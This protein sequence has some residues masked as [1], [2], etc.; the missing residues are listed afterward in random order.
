MSQ[1]RK[2]VLPSLLRRIA[3]ILLAHRTQPRR[4]VASNGRI[5]KATVVEAAYRR[6]STNQG[7]QEER[8]P[9]PDDQ[10]T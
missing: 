3:D 6:Y 2:R 8:G 1:A 7:G 9:R 4:L 10:R 5:A